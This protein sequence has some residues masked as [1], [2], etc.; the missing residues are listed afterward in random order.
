[1]SGT[2]ESEG[3]RDSDADHQVPP[4][5]IEDRAIFLLR[6]YVDYKDA[7][8]GH[9]G[10]HPTED[11]KGRLRRVANDAAF[12]DLQAILGRRGPAAFRVEIALRSVEQR[13]EP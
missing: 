11:L 9:C 8:L 2:S 6:R 13:R 12:E 4:L 10:S 5:E 7:L 3:A 1:M